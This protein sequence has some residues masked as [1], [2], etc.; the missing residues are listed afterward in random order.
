MVKKEFLEAISD[1]TGA[2]KKTVEEFYDTFVEVLE[3]TLKHGEKVQLSGF[4][5]F[6]IKEK[7]AREGINPATGEKIK[8]AASKKPVFKP[9]KLFKEAFLPTSKKK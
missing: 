2:S 4:G 9:A 8:I 7:P 5:N 6:E 1:K 3:K